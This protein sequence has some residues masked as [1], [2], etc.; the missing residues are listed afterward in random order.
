[1][2]Y[3]DVKT[4]SQKWVDLNLM[5]LPP[6]LVLHIASLLIRASRQ[7]LF[8]DS[9]NMKMSVKDNVTI[10]LAG[11]SM[12]I[13]PAASGE[14]LKT[15]F[16]NKR[17]GHS[18]TRTI[19]VVL[20]ER[21]HDLLAVIT[22]LALILFFTHSFEMQL[23]IGIMSIILIGI[24]IIM[25]KK[26]IFDTI[27]SKLSRIPLA[28]KSLGGFPM[29]YDTLYILSQRRVMLLGWTIGIASWGIDAIA[30]YLGFM[31][32]HLNYNF[33]ESTAIMYTA[34]ILGAIS[35]LPGGVGVTETSMM[36]FLV[37]SGLA[38]STSSALILF[39]R[40]TSIW[41]STIIGVAAVKILTKRDKNKDVASKSE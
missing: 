14:V 15:Y 5:F 3:S 6:I 31:A 30:T 8:L 19:P 22:I 18:Y 38:V 4:F 1:M 21:Y 37:K 32:F 10:H 36:G 28:K 39:T 12:I 24:F 35:F 2:L 40:L 20:V 41:F 34:T 23:V 11:L 17:F 26:T 33:I 29:F 9:T 7:K 16:L 25:R 13:T 27:V